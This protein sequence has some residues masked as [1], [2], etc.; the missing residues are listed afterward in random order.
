MKS[1]M[2][3]R[4]GESAKRS[5]SRTVGAMRFRKC[6]VGSGWRSHASS[7]APPMMAN[8]GVPRSASATTAAGDDAA[9]DAR[10]RR[11]RRP[12]PEAEL[13]AERRFVRLV[14]GHLVDPVSVLFVRQVG[15][16]ADVPGQDE[17]RP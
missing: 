15:V 9:H 8:S 11:R 13:G 14:Q 6:W 7:L 5:S 17:E 2:V 10:S 16:D 4:I 3:T 12:R 1:G